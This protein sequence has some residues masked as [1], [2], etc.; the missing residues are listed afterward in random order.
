MKKSSLITLFVGMNDKDTRQENMPKEQQIN[1]I[2]SILVSFNAISGGTISEASG[3]YTMNDGTMTFEKTY[4][5][6]LLNVSV[7]V[8]RR[9]CSDLAHVFNQESVLMVVSG[10]GADFVE[11]MNY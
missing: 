3:F 4:R 1:K 2:T 9:A 5:I 8:A 7:D 10:C 6:E 11:R